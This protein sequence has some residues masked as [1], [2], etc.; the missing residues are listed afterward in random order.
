[1]NFEPEI[2]SKPESG[3]I[4]FGIEKREHINDSG[5]KEIF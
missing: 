1:M 4:E 5:E 3:G 2:K